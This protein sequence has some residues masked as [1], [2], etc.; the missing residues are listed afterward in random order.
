MCGRWGQ[1]LDGHRSVTGG[2]LRS[3]V[4]GFLTLATH[5]LALGCAA[6]RG[7]FF[8][9]FINAHFGRCL[10]SGPTHVMSLIASANM[11]SSVAWLGQRLSAFREGLLPLAVTPV[12]RPKP[13]T[14]CPCTALSPSD[15]ETPYRDCASPRGE[16][17][18][19]ESSPP[20]WPWLWAHP[21]PNLTARSRRHARQQRCASST[22]PP[23]AQI[24]AG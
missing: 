14:T 11:G 18:R 13:L 17:R 9:Q 23:S 6:M 8:E 16:R 5:T 1:V 4:A 7:S 10:A 2:W 19:V 21:A 3:G 20:Q 24:A 15:G 22:N 12:K